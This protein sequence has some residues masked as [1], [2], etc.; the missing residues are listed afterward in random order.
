MK[1]TE[2]MDLFFNQSDYSEK[3]IISYRNDIVKFMNLV[4]Q[5]YEKDATVEQFEYV[6]ADIIKAH[7]AS[8]NKNST[9]NR[10]ITVI[11]RFLTFLKDSG[12]IQAD[13][14]YLED[15]QSVPVDT[16]STEVIEG[17]E[18][19]IFLSEMSKEKSRSYEKQLML[20]TAL[21]TGIR[22]EDLLNLKWENFVEDEDGNIYMMEYSKYRNVDMKRVSNE[23]FEALQGIRTDSEKVFGMLSAKAIAGS[24]TRTKVRLQKAGRKISYTSFTK[25]HDK[26]KENGHEMN[27]NYI[28]KNVLERGLIMSG[29]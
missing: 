8:F 27:M 4:F 21:E 3:T 19:I 28:M 20:L 17:E 18:I 2:A 7:Y 11:R 1:A 22:M 26:F 16:E 12:L 6:D 29:Q 14:S 25:A 15:V 9:Y 24:I 23:F 13:I 10:F 5:E